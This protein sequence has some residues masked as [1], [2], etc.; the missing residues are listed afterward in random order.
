MDK[1]SESKVC[2]FVDRTLNYGGDVLP[3]FMRR[4]DNV[5]TILDVGGGWGR[6][7]AYAKD[8][9]LDASLHAIECNPE[10]IS[11]L[12][13]N[14]IATWQLDIEKEKFPFQDESVDLVICNQVLE[15]VK[16]IFLILHE[17]TR[18]IAVG[19]HCIVGV[20]NVA[21]FHNRI[22]LL[23]GMHPTQVK[24]CSAHIRCFSKNDFLALLEACFPGGYVLKG[25][26]G[27]QFYPFPPAVARPMAR[28]FPTMAYS[29]FFLL[30]KTKKYTGTF[31]EYPQKALLETN[32]RISVEAVSDAGCESQCR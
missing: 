1:H 30:Q 17:I 14:S 12:T 22:G 29:I 18:V 28:L 4:L 13:A 26:A 27:A 25:F 19:G 8:I 3:V 5:K 10:C 7:L 15:H 16:E 23:F 31:L 9:F 11:C 24:S 32:F 6:D 21:S 2:H 20:P